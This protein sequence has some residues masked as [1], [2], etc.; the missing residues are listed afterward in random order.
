MPSV[1]L[2]DAGN[3]LVHVNLD[4]FR[5]LLRLRGCP[6]AADRVERAE[7]VVRHRLDTPQIIAQTNDQSR[8]ILYYGSILDEIGAPRSILDDLQAYHERRNLWDTVRPDTPDVLARL[9]RR[10]RLG[11]VSNSNGTVTDVLTR[12]G[13][14]PLFD[15][16]VDSH[17]VGVE[18][19]DPRIFEIAL[20]RMGARPED[21]VYVGDIFH[22][23]V[24]GARNAGIRGILLDPGDVHHDKACERIRALSD[25]EALL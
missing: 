25:L 15:T 6:E 13:L 8:W 10:F 23:D 20:E 1:I 22:I 12:M 2:L 19:P 24:V 11:V 21:A 9:R 7:L 4:E 17:V 3:T 16:I 18:K 5:R 14:A